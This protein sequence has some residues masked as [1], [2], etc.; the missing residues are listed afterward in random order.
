MGCYRIEIETK[1]VPKARPRLGANGRMYTPRET[2]EFEELIGWT[3]RSVVRKPIEKPVKVN[4]DVYSKTKADI[5][6]IAKAILDGL[7]GVAFL[8]DRQVVDLRIRKLP[9]VDCEKIVISIKETRSV[10]KCKNSG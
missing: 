1:P 5:D 6:N 9:P 4:I 7:S 10:Q 8:D 3:T 2:K